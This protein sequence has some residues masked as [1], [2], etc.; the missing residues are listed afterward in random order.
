[1]LISVKKRLKKERS[2]NMN[3]DSNQSNNKCPWC[4]ESCGK[5]W[6]SWSKK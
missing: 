3:I 2:L 6:C 4:K 5:S 1:M